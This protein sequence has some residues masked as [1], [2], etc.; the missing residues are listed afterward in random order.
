M[1]AAQF[2]QTLADIPRLGIIQTPADGG[3]RVL[4]TLLAAILYE[5]RFESGT[6]EE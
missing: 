4:T 5:G 3:R 6:C 2:A 1:Q